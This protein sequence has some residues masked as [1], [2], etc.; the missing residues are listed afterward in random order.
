M[1]SSLGARR[2][3]SRSPPEGHPP[4]K[5]FIQA[6]EKPEHLI[7]SNVRY[8]SQHPNIK[9]D[10][11]CHKTLVPKIVVQEYTQE[12][13]SSP[14]MPFTYAQALMHTGSQS[15]PE[16][17]PKSAAQEQQLTEE[18]EFSLQHQQVQHV[19][20]SVQWQELKQ[21]QEVQQ[22]QMSAHTQ[23]QKQKEPPLEKQQHQQEMHKYEVQQHVVTHIE[24]GTEVKQT[25]EHH[26]YTYSQETPVGK[27][28]LSPQELKSRKAQAMK[29]R[30]W[31]QKPASGEFKGLAADQKQDSTQESIQTTQPLLQSERETVRLQPEEHV[32]VP[33]HPQQ[34]QKEQQGQ[35]KESENFQQQ[36]KEQVEHETVM[37]QQ[38]QLL[39]KEKQPK[40]KKQLL[41]QEHEKPLLKQ[42]DLSSDATVKSQNLT[43]TQ[44]D[45]QT[46]VKNLQGHNT[47]VQSKSQAAVQ[48]HVKS[49]SVS[50][51]ATES[52][53]P[54]K[55]MH[56]TNVIQGQSQTQVHS[57]PQGPTQLQLQSQTC[58][59]E[60]PLP[61]TQPQGLAPG[62]AATQTQ[63]WTQVKPPSPMQVSLQGQVPVS[64]HIQL[65]SHPQSWAPV[66]PPSPKPIMHDQVVTQS[67]NQSQIHAQPMPHPQTHT[68]PPVRAQTHSQSTAQPQPHSPLRAHSQAY[69]QSVPQA[70][71]YAKQMAQQSHSS[72]MTQQNQDQFVVQP[73]LQPLSQYS[74]PAQSAVQHQ[75]HISQSHTYSWTQ[76]RASFPMS[77]PHPQIVPQLPSYP[78][79]Y[80]QVQSVPQQ[81]IPEKELQNQAAAQQRYLI[82]QQYP[83][84]V[85]Q[86]SKSQAHPSWPQAGSQ[87]DPQIGQPGY[88]HMG[89]SQPHMQTQNQPWTQTPPQV[90]TQISMHQQPQMKG[91][92]IFQTQTHQGQLQQQSWAQAPP[93]LHPQPYPQSQS[94]QYSQ[95][96]T[97][98]QAQSQMQTQV[99]FQLQPQNQPLPQP[100]S[101]AKFLPGHPPKQ[102]QF[103]TS[104]PLQPQL[105]PQ[106]QQP[107]QQKH[108]SQFQPKQNIQSAQLKGEFP[109]K[110]I[111]QSPNKAEPLSKLQGESAPLS[112]APRPQVQ[113]PPEPQL[114]A[115]S[116]L[117]PTVPLASPSEVQSPTQPKHQLQFPSQP[118]VQ[119]QSP[120]L[121]K[122]QM[123]PALEAQSPT[124]SNVLSPT[125]N[126]SQGPPHVDL[127]AQLPQTIPQ[128]Q[129]PPQPEQ[130]QSQANLLSQVNVLPQSLP[131]SPD[132]CVTPPTLAQAPPQAYTEAYTKAQALARNGFEEAKHCLQ[133]HIRETINIFEDKRI[134]V[135]QASLKEVNSMI[136]I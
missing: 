129:S 54:L 20:Q 110:H 83:K 38:Q 109:E 18:K 136:L 96:Q 81:W 67:G 108:Q 60:G 124:Q 126:K 111:T 44:L 74:T 14:K 94:Q 10:S 4:S 88:S 16:G 93:H 56:Q 52:Q 64:S 9:F 122:D 25:N 17:K 71:A 133:E 50:H 82:S 24:V 121:P 35:M 104:Q 40:Q 98:H 89:Y 135:K 70:Q 27:P 62:L 125:Q 84:Q 1:L 6:K 36:Q 79:G 75:G 107:P 23:Q 58:V 33:E 127:Q 91:Y 34:Q 15:P 120:P 32:K 26:K 65:R 87:V 72:P 134:S 68:H 51:I 78:E 19:T 55:T 106:F 105:T 113:M 41:Q 99:P 130:L 114:Q 3:R 57:Q 119:A 39:H 128:S 13:V 85:S 69:V 61:S 47:P 80:T 22:Q 5:V 12:R 95:H 97:Q 73:K 66:R 102:P 7:E 43:M 115:K 53:Q 30:P 42:T 112:E 90:I 59:L 117:Q 101:H 118:Q 132:L 103:P 11:Q 77:G 92:E 21:P 45:Q 29:N 131:E 8:Q 100:S 86:A 31:L 2:D 76:V 48:V 63:T 46:K 28:A 116:P 123:G 49:T 37:H